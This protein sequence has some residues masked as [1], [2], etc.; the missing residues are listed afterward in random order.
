MQHNDH[1]ITFFTCLCASHYTRSFSDMLVNAHVYS[2]HAQTWPVHPL[3]IQSGH[4]NTI[5][6]VKIMTACPPPA[7]KKNKD[8]NKRGSVYHLQL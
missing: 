2:V 6:N 4:P 3:K 5:K 8:A 7:E 1:V